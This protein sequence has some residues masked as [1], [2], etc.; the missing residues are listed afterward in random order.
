MLPQKNLK[1]ENSLNGWD[2]EILLLKSMFR[3]PKI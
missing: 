2:I 3:I 1:F